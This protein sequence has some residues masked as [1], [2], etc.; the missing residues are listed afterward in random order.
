MNYFLIFQ[1]ERPI[2]FGSTA[3]AIR[4]DEVDIDVPE[5]E[6]TISGWGALEV[7]QF[8][9]QLIFSAIIFLNDDTG[10]RTRIY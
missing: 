8:K 3:Q 2:V 9:Y 1:L 7:G 5:Y 6:S 4:Y 10:R